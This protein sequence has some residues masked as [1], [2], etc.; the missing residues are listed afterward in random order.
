[1]VLHYFEKL[2][3]RTS[4][5]LLQ[6]FTGSSK[7]GP[8]GSP[9]A[10]KNVSTTRQKHEGGKF[11]KPF[12]APCEIYHCNSGLRTLIQGFPSRPLTVQCFF[13]TSRNNSTKPWGWGPWLPLAR[14][15]VRGQS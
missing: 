15:D 12:A 5:P 6:G 10:Y 7:H 1:M 2:R 3:F 14:K 11:T 9:H 13:E 4:S 8:N